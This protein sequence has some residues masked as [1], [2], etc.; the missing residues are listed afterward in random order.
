MLKAL[1]ITIS[2]WFLNLTTTPPLPTGEDID[3]FYPD[4]NL[5]FIFDSESK[6]EATPN[7]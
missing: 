1:L 3:G 6:E 4:A 5:P 2:N 7:K